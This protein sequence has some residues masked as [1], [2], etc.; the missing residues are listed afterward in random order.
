VAG[1]VAGGRAALAAIEAADHD[2]LAATRHPDKRHLIA[3]LIRAY[4]RGR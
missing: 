3:G 1:Y 4:T 2:V